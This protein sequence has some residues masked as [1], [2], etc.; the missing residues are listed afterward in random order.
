MQHSWIC[1]AC[2]RARTQDHVHT[3]TH[4][5]AHKAVYTHTRRHARKY[6]RSQ[7]H[8]HSRKLVRT[9]ARTQAPARTHTACTPCMPC[10]LT[11]RRSR[12]S[13]SVCHAR[14]APRASHRTLPSAYILR[15]SERGFFSIVFMATPMASATIS[16]AT[17]DLDC[18]V[19]SSRCPVL[20][21]ST[22][23]SRTA[24]RGIL[25]RLQIR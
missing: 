5:H 23:R 17:L 16:F 25:P 6:T 19:F 11:K 12:R 15:L 8:I 2:T 3:H 4:M 14:R 7:T 9:H 10:T 24:P 21:S 13:H 1:A 20:T 18:V 22:S